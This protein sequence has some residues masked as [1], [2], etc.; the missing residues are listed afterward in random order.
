MFLETKLLGT[1]H[2]WT[3]FF[4]EFFLTNFLGGTTLFPTFFGEQYFFGEKIIF[5]TKDF[6][7]GGDKDFGDK[8]AFD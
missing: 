5:W 2:F 3:I 8:N 6:F 7:W 4:Y 1:K